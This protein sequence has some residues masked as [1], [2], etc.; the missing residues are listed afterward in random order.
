MKR[1]MSRVALALVLLVALVMPVAANRLASQDTVWNLNGAPSDNNNALG[2]YAEGAGTGCTPY[3]VTYLQWNLATI[4]FDTVINYVGVTLKAIGSSS[5]SGATLGLYQLSTNLWTENTLNGS[6][7]AHPVPG[8]DI[9]LATTTVPNGIV[10]PTSIAFSGT[11]PGNSLVQYV[12]SHLNTGG[13]RIVSFAV[14][15]SG[16]C[17]PNFSSSVTFE[18]KE[19]SLGSGAPGP[20]LLVTQSDANAV[21][22]SF[23]RA[24]DPPLNWPLIAAGLLVAALLAGVGAYR[25]RLSRTQAR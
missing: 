6:L 12:Q 9:P 10:T 11:G 5:T 23:F 13:D 22:L 21:T 2:L 24:A 15:F 1:A 25:W 20:D 18:D 3:L 17:D 8:T 19:G 16:G 7:P 4:P 14:A